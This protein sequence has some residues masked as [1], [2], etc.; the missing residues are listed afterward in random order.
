[1]K[2]RKLKFQLLLE[3]QGAA[4]DRKAFVQ[5]CLCVPIIPFT[6]YNHFG[7]VTSQVHIA[8][9]FIWDCSWKLVEASTVPE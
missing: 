4:V 1:M 3:M 8:M 7:L 5:I 2:F 6:S 9:H